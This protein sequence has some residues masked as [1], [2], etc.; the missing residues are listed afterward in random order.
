MSFFQKL[1]IF[2]HSILNPTAEDTLQRQTMKKLE[3]EIKQLAPDL[4]KNSLIQENFAET[5][6]QLF[7]NTKDIA[8]LLEETI[9]STDRDISMHFEEQLILTGFDKESIDILESLTY[10]KRKE[11]AREASSLTR[12][13]ENEHKQLEK[14]GKQMNT[15]EFRK[16]DIVLDKIKQLYDITRYNYV[17]ALKI[18]D[19]GFSAAPGYL[20]EFQP[21]PPD[22]LES[23]LQDLYYVTAD[24]D[25]TNSLFN[26]VLALK[27]LKHGE[28]AATQSAETLKN[29]FRKIQGILKHYFTKETITCLIR[30]AKK[31]EDFVPDK[32][33]YKG[34]SLQKYADLLENKFRV[35]ENRLKGEL[36]DEKISSEIQRMF[37]G[38][39]MV[40]VAGYNAELNNQLIQSTPCSFIWVLPLQILKNFTREYFDKH[41]KP[42]LN[43]IV[44]E[45]F[46][47]NPAYKSD[48]SS[49]VFACNDLSD[50]ISNYE[51]KF[52]RSNDFDEANITGL[53]HDSHKDKAFENTLKELIDRINKYTKDFLQ[54]EVSNIFAL[55]KLINDLILES[56]KPTSDVISN[57]KVLMISSRNKESSEFM[58]ANFPIWQLFL[59]IMKNYVIIKSV[60]K[61]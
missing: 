13:F 26:A 52:Q 6:R 49:V 10:E 57:L 31:N 1:A 34:N 11:G 59:E 24:M 12:F 7:I 33:S 43:N 47:N 46:F 55:Y 53:I 51:K 58:E 22:L 28:K 38:I 15:P 45:G 40:P 25:I 3:S 27:K 30:L 42:L 2:F 32:G 39:Q 8:D 9:C 48:F 56:K 35:D 18:F 21:I 4:Y 17:T 19:S 14:V 41:I 29:S 44:I 54:E 50:R 20:P 5:L 61:K 36:Q 60:E 37:E 23:S 16:I